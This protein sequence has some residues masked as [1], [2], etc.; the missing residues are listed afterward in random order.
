M[1][2]PVTITH[3]FNASEVRQV[4]L[5]PQGGVVKAMMRKGARVESAAKRNLQSDPRRVNTG[6]LRSSIVTELQ[7]TS[8]GFRVVVGTNV[9]YAKFV[10]EGTG[11][12]GPKHALIRPKVKKALRWRAKGGHASKGGWT[13]SRYSRGMRPNHFLL[14]ALPAARG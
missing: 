6:R 14:N 2:M 9:A 1:L 13:Y 12:Y 5:S 11:L 8:G 3:R 4:L 10:H 7:M